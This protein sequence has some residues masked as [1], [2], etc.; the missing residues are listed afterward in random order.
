MPLEKHSLLN[1]FPEHHHTIRHLK[2]NDRHFVKLFDLYHQLDDE[3]HRLEQANG[4]VADDYLES[5][6]LNRVQLK[7]QLFSLI[8]KTEK[9]Q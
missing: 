8:I 7:D 9:A 5:L 6:K 1:D 4:P 2:M 3:V